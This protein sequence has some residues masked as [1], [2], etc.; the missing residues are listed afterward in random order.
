MGAD[1]RGQPGPARGWLLPPKTH[2]SWYFLKLELPAQLFT[3]T[4]AQGDSDF[5]YS[6]FKHLGCYPNE[7]TREQTLFWLHENTTAVAGL[8]LKWAKMGE[9]EN[10]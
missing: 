5:G 1:S 10:K 9:K 2:G 3:C 6:Q 8:P 7:M 4:Q